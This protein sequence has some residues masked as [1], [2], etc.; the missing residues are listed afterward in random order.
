MIFWVS[1]HKYSSD[2][3]LTCG[4][5]I[6]IG[7]CRNEKDSATPPENGW[8]NNNDKSA[9]QM[10]IEYV[11]AAPTG[12]TKIWDDQTNTLR[13]HHTQRNE[14]VDTVGEANALDARVQ[15]VFCSHYNCG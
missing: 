9:S 6:D 15:T 11:K 2:F 3:V 13:Y 10:R 12:W 5:Q 7:D 8:I 14:T 1:K 4:L